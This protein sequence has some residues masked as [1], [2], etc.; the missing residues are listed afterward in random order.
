MTFLY[1]WANQA[2]PPAVLM[3]ARVRRFEQPTVLVVDDDPIVREIYQIALN[4]LGYAVNVAR[5]G[6][7]ALQMAATSAPELILLD[8]RMPRMDGV[9]VLELLRAD[10][11]TRGI[12]VV[13]LSNYDDDSIVKRCLG[14]GAKE[15]LVK[16]N[17]DPAD[18]GAIVARWIG[19]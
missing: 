9:E 17:L 13:M 19:R 14:L 4:R 7:T 11:H 18:L 10:A 15:Y 6:P 3:R 1:S 8:V 12:P 2:V 5:D 16:A